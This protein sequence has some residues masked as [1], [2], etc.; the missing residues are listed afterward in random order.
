MAKQ[1][2][3]TILGIYLEETFHLKGLRDIGLFQTKDPAKPTYVKN[4]KDYPAIAARIQFYFGLKRIYDYS[5]MEPFGPGIP[6]ENELPADVV[7]P[8]EWL[9]QDSRLV[10]L[11]ANN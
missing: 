5:L 8:G 10:N 11:I 1:A 9:L 2:E 7:T 3:I 6:A 4:L